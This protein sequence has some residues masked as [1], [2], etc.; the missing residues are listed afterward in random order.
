MKVKFI[1]FATVIVVI[2]VSI[3]LV[4]KSSSK[5]YEMVSPISVS[6]LPEIKLKPMFYEENNFFS[7]IEKTKNIKV[8]KNIQ[9]IVVPHHLLAGEYIAGL[10]KRASGENFS[11]IVVIGPNHENISQEILATTLASWQTPWGEVETDRGL[12]NNFLADFGEQTVFEA[13][14]NEH[15]VGAMAPF[16]KYYFPEAK[17][18]PVIINSYANIQDA[19]KLSIW[20]NKNLPEHS[21]IVVSTD[22]SHYL[23][24]VEA[25][26]NDLETQQWIGERNTEMIAR[27]NND[28]ID[29]PISLVTIL[30]LAQKRNWQIEE[31]YHG[32]S[33]DFSLIKPSETT[34]Y[35]GLVFR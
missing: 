17:I 32:N 12:V 11:T 3:C 22:F 34:S 2:A 30:L 25:D 31:I 8:E 26:Q 18:V 1:I 6:V 4:S 33:F 24:R 28:Y 13:F 15:S 27:L 5:K 20:L 14:Q 21:L 23:D 9:A 19:N 10:F 35:F 16:I 29:S 7:S